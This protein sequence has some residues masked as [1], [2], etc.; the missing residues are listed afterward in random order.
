VGALRVIW[1]K[2]AVRQN[3]QIASWY[4]AN[5]GY[6][7][8][9]RYFAGIVD[10]IATLSHAPHIGTLDER[11]SSGKYTYYSFLSHPKYRIEYRFTKTTL[12]IVAIRSTLQSASSVGK[13]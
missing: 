5:M 13:V 4:E 3:N 8:A 12:H 10:T 6:Q 7:A 11:R 1:H 2:R 9:S